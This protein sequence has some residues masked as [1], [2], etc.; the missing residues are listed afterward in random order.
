MKESFS[1]RTK[2]QITYSNFV[3]EEA[4]KAKAQPLPSGFLWLNGGDKTALQLMKVWEE[5]F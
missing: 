4:E 3:P 2:W 5:S 1:L